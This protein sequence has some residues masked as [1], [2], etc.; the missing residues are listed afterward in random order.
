MNKRKTIFTRI[1]VSFFFASLLPITLA[2]FLITASYQ[3]MTENLI[4]RIYNLGKYVDPILIIAAQEI[5]LKNHETTILTILIVGIMLTITVFLSIMITRR[6]SGP[7]RILLQATQAI[8]KGEDNV[9]IAITGDDEFAR[10]GE[11]FNEMAQRLSSARN[12]LEQA[13]KTLEEKVKERTAEL[14]LLYNEL[15]KTSDKIYESN[16]LKSEFLAN[17]SH[18][19]R[20]PLNAILGYTDLMAEGIYGELVGKQKES[21]SKIRRNAESLMKL[22]SDILDISKIEYGKIN[23]MIE[24]F[25]PKELLTNCSDSLAPLFM[26]KS[27]ELRVDIPEAMPRMVSDKGKIQQIVLNLLSNALKFTD[28]GWVML[29]AEPLSNRR[30]QIQIKDTG[31]GISPQDQKIIFDQFR[32]LDGSTS[33][34]Y[35]GV[36]LG[37][38]ICKKFVNILGGDINVTSSPG[39]GSA[40]TVILPTYVTTEKRPEEKEPERP[41]E[42]DTKYILA[43]DD[44][45]DILDLLTDSLEPEGYK[46]IRCM[47]GDEGIRK[48]KDL[49]PYAITLDI[50]MPYRDGWSV[51]RELKSNPKTSHIPVIIISII[52]DKALGFSLGVDDYIV[53]PLKRHVLL[54]KLK[55]FEERKSVDN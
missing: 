40:F 30:I 35:G 1:F 41:I 28:R 29:S 11:T 4:Q 9:R 54:E 13:N 33:R 36:G 31:I 5:R 32:Q 3:D 18:E 50:M 15:K 49:L 47:D 24:E 46:I 16:Q 14:T 23:L 10:L 38:A 25:D 12:E 19:L 22:I 45:T 17:I 2:A 44:D 51:L 53:K 39:K 48:T 7:I 26:R 34:K 42:R 6:I 43:I 27:L 21:L 8:T 55:S 37:L 52:D 20:T